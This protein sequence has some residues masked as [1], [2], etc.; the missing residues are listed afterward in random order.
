MKKLLPLTLAFLALAF[1]SSVCAEDGWYL[2]ASYN[3]Q[4]ISSDDR[5]FNTA[6]II[7]GYQYNK[8]FALESRLS[9][10]VSGHSTS[11]T[12][13][14]ASDI[15]YKEDIDSQ[16]SLFIKSSYPIDKSINLYVLVGY[17]TTKIKTNRSM[18]ITDSNGAVLSPY[19]FKK[20]Y[21]GASYGFGLNYQLNEQ[22]NLFIDYQVLPDFE[23]VSNYSKSWNSASIGVN[24]SF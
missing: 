14:Q 3:A 5:E 13:N 22:F 24:Y 9:T 12:F 7:T 11:L 8:Y 1:T 20:T 15:N 23:P 2:G 17:T 16:A 18:I 21:S 4:D 19:D 6:G 10:G